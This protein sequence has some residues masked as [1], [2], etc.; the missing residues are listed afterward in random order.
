MDARDSHKCRPTWIGR[1]SSANQ[2]ENLNSSG[3]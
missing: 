1:E 2:L 3:K